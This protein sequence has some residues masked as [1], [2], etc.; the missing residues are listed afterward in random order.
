[1]HELVLVLGNKPYRSLQIGKVLDCFK[2]NVRCNLGIPGFNNGSI[3][4]E[5]MV[6]SHISMYFIEKQPM[7]PETRK[8]YQEEY[9]NKH[10]NFCLENMCAEDYNTVKYL[11]PRTQIY[12]RFL[13]SVNCPYWFSKM[14]RTGYAALFEKLLEGRSV[15]VSNFSINDETRESFYVKE[16]VYKR[17]DPNENVPHKCHE[18][19]DEINIIRWL[20]DNNY[21]DATL[22]ML[23][24]VAIPTLESDGLHPSEFII[25]LL[26]RTYG[27]VVIT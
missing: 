7:P 5:L 27:E 12:N 17:E 9:N 6:C 22:C 26:N 21:V 3:T 23:K 8:E 4:D 13:K 25:E 10:F 15:A 24:D 1:M 20:H 19:K 18:K 11:E 16:E 2:N 14:P